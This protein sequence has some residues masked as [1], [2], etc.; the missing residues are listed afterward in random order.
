MKQPRFS[1][2]LKSMQDLHGVNQAEIARRLGVEPSTV[3]FW[4]NGR[5]PGGRD[6]LALAKMFSVDPWLLLGAD[7]KEPLPK[8]D[9]PVIGRP[10]AIAIDV[11]DS[12]LNAEKAPDAGADGIPAERAPNVSSKKA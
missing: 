3:H 2:N 4:R 8:E 9:A 12:A 11:F 10:P 6:L 7:A 5:I 1:D